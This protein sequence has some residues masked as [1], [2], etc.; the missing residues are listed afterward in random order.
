MQMRDAGAVNRGRQADIEIQAQRL[1]DL[2]G[3]ELAK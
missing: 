2:L 3:E 1:G